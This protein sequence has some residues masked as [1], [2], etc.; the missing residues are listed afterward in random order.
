MPNEKLMIKAGETEWNKN[1]MKC[2]FL[3]WNNNQWLSVTKQGLKK[4]PS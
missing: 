2:S 3:L 1:E 4:G